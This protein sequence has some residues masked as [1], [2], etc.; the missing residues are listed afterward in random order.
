MNFD[1]PKLYKKIV[2]VSNDYL[3][4]AQLSSC[5]HRKNYYFVVLEPP[6][7]LHKYWRNEFIKLNNILAKTEA[8]I[9]IFLN[10]KTEMVSLIK[11]QLKIPE[12]QYVYINTQ[13][14][15]E[16]FLKKYSSVFKGILECPPDR[17]KVAHAL[18]EAK[19]K[20]FKLVIKA[21]AK[22]TNKVNENSEHLL[23]CDS[24][25]NLLPVILGNYAFS[26]NADIKFFKGDDRYNPIEIYSVLSD[27]R[28]LE[29]R[30]KIARG[31]KKE[32][33]EK[34]HIELKN[35]SNYKFITFFTDDF[36]YG[37]FFPDV[38]STH[39]LNKLLVGQFIAD[40]VA[41]PL[42][43]TT[44][45]LLVDTGFFPN[46]ETDFIKDILIKQ[47]VTIKELRNDQFSNVDLD[48][49]IQI[50]PYDVLFICSHGKFPTGTRFK[51]KFN[52]KNSIDHIILVDVLDSFGLTGKGD[53]EN[54]IVSVQTITEF[55][56]LDDQPWY[57]KKYKPGSSKT[58][59]EDFI[60]IKRESWE[61]IEKEDVTMSFNNAIETKDP[62]G[63][64]VPMIHGISDPFSSPFVFNNACMSTYTIGVNFI[65]AG[66][67][68]YI[69][70]VRK[71]KDPVAIKTAIGF[72]DKTISQNK[73]FA[74]S[75]WEAQV[76]AKIPT[77]DRVYTCIG[78][79]FQ[80][81]SFNKIDNTRDLL[82]SRI[83]RSAFMRLKSSKKADLEDS[84]KERYLDAIDFLKKIAMNI[85][86]QEK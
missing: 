5:F 24:N 80:K 41:E 60:A 27:M 77:D 83:A 51:I 13:E 21:G 37:Y 84:V 32:I 64:Y 23:A 54:P 44:S 30:N 38:P 22:Y 46:S 52:D 63:P 31:I 42:V 16:T 28:G 33:S 49:H 15:L 53:P 12:N 40:A 14:E 25:E 66:S 34:L 26:I 62:L 35:I 75:L 29:E 70:T 71:I 85:L 78:C 79:H 19:R 48:N 69:G 8:E 9:I 36:Q 58:I 74:L 50:Y 7:S 3:M 86:E 65:F 61:V 47:N 11:N 45:A 73:S 57:Q 17:E 56:E 68:F 81:F 2:C 76:E 4:S 39:I 43:R 55:V 18:L 72:F 6:R 10:L 1:P 20:E 82:K 67:S 59:V